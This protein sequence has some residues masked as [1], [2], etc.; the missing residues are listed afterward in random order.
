MSTSLSSKGGTKRVLITGATGF[1]GG[2][3]V[4]QAKSA[5]FEVYIALRRESNRAKA[6]ALGAK[7]VL[8]DYADE[9][10]MAQAIAEHTAE[11]EPAWH[12]VIH[13]AG[14]TKAKH[15]AEFA[16]VNAKHTRR[17]CRALRSSACP[18]ERFVLMSSLSSYGIP[19]GDAPIRASDSQRPNTAYGKSKMLAEQYVEQSGLP[20]TILLPTGV[21][22]PGDEDYLLAI[23]SISKGL[24][25]MSGLSAQVLTFV[26]GEDV[27]RAALLLLSRSE[28]E[29]KRYIISDGATYTDEEFGTLTQ[30]LL[31]QKHCLHL[32][33]P[34]ALLWCICQL[35]SLWTAVSGRTT[36]LNR[37]KYP[38]L[39]QRS[40]RCDASPL[41]T[42]GFTPR[43]DLREGLRQTIRHA[44]THGK[45]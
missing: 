3:L 22:G 25:M 12:Y 31:G 28:A 7:I 41:L 39:A 29:G 5:G 20:F 40:W 2:H 19:E 45:L 1:I 35:G 17:L 26:Y 6:E 24:N 37:D 27:A 36:P 4:E 33:A 8:L 23:K 18:P 34:L 15:P 30:E 10:Q 43:Y 16:E 38:I 42:L 13:N 32:R 9:V 11:G 21:Y 14:I 44:R